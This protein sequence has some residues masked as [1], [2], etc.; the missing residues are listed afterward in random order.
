MPGFDN[1]L[2][3][4]FFCADYLA[5]NLKSFCFLGSRPGAYNG[6]TSYQLQAKQLFLKVTTRP[7]TALIQPSLFSSVSKELKEVM[8]LGSG[9]SEQGT[10][11]SPVMA[12]SSTRA[13]PISLKS[14]LSFLFSCFASRLC[15]TLWHRRPRVK[16]LKPR[17]PRVASPTHS[18]AVQAH[19]DG[20]LARGLLEEHLL[21]H[22]R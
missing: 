12:S 4:A 15:P 6:E 20:C 11:L 18:P 13:P 7:I 17:Q 10:A 16:T 19:L 22:S 21:H 8:V 9:K 1:S 14:S 5:L 2:L 3:R